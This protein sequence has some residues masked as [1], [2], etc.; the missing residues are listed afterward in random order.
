MITNRVIRN[1]RN[2]CFFSS[3]GLKFR[4]KVWAVFLL[5][6][7]REKSVPCPVLASRACWRSS[8]FLGVW[9][10][11]SSPCCRPVAFFPGCLCVYVVFLEEYWSLVLGP[12]LIQD[13]FISVYLHLQRPCFQ[14]R[15]LS[16]IPGG[17][18][19]RRTLSS[20]PD[21]A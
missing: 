19:F 12:I 16:D 7:L 17:H 18:E 13:D 1:N 15:S 9:L 5:E 6:P 2:V 8:T 3:G 4:I 10:P 14:L 11:P 20:L 21:L